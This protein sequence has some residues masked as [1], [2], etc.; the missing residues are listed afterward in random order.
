ME[1]KY[2]KMF[3]MEYIFFKDK[4]I[5]FFRYSFSIFIYICYIYMINDCLL[6]FRVVL[7]GFRVVLY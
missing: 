3:Y 7:L 5:V 4:D 1:E 2:F 6:D